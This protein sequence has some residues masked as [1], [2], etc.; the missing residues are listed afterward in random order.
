M[1]NHFFVITS[2]KNSLPIK[3]GQ[4]ACFEKNLIVF[5][6]SFLIDTEPFHLLLV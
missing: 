4:A 2:L 1:S 3:Q 5:Q 6:K